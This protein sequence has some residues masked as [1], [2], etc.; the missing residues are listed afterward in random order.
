MGQSD[1]QDI[2]DPCHLGSDILS[3]EY[4]KERSR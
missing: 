2:Q 4:N 3:G 1:E